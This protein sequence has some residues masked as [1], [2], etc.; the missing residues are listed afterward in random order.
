MGEPF[1]SSGPNHISQEAADKM[2]KRGDSKADWKAG[3]TVEIGWNVQAIHGGRY[4]YFL[5][6]DGSDSWDC[7]S[8]SPLKNAESKVWL[9]VDWGLTSVNIK[10]D[11]LTIP[12]DV[13]GDCTLGW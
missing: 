13:A 12:K 11:N 9:D 1:C 6:C 7:F 5:C 8:K 10:W 4:A 2:A 3:D